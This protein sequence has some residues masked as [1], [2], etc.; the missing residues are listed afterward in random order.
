MPVLIQIASV[1]RRRMAA[2]VVRVRVG[3]RMSC[4]GR[5]RSMRVPAREM[6][7]MRSVIVNRW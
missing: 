3:M 2:V 1:G 7:A 5:L 4:L 6:I